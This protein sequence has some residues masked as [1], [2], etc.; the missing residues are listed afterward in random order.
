MTRTT[1]L[2]LI[3]FFLIISRTFYGTSY[4]TIGNIH[5]IFI[6]INSGYAWITGEELH[7]SFHSPFG[8]FYHFLNYVSL[9]ITIAFPDIFHTFDMMFL[10]SI[11]FSAVLVLMFLVMRISQPKSAQIPFWILLLIIPLTFQTRDVSQVDARYP[12]WYGIYNN[13]LWA[14]IILQISHC[15]SW[16]ECGKNSMKI[17]VFATLQATC[18]L[19]CLLF[20]INFVIS[21]GILCLS[22]LILMNTV[23]KKVYLIS[24]ITVTLFAIFA[25][26]LTGYSYTAYFNDLLVTLDAKK[27]QSGIDIKPV[28][29]MIIFILIIQVVR[30]HKQDLI[31]Y[32]K[33]LFV[34]VRLYL[35]QIINNRLQIHLFVFDILIAFS[36]L[37]GVIGDFHRP[38]IFYVLVLFIFQ[39]WIMLRNG[40]KIKYTP[41]PMILL[42]IVGA[43]FIRNIEST[44]QVA[45][46][47]TKEVPPIEE[48]FTKWAEVV[49]DGSSTSMSFLVK[50]TQTLDMFLKKG[51]FKRANDWDNYILTSS[52]SKKTPDDLLLRGAGYRNAQYVED[53]NNVL[54][55]LKTKDLMN[56]NNVKVNY[57]AFT[58]PFPF[59]L[60]TQL[61]D[62]TPHWLHI[63]TTH[64]KK[65][66]IKYMD[67]LQSSD[68]VIMP[69]SAV[70]KE[71]QLF[72]NCSF[73]L[74]NQQQKQ[75]FFIIGVEGLSIIFASEN[76][77]K[78][79]NYPVTL[80][81]DYDR[82]KQECI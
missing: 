53:I 45:M 64:S 10:S 36:I 47:K 34:R 75:K 63:G 25:V 20:K 41:Y 51:V 19:I 14:L 38:Y 67:N 52:Y 30:Y 69:V 54:R 73:Y 70:I 24:G 62:Q 9:S 40:V 42:A 4:V 59:L 48:N 8:Y 15:F 46:K 78:Q 49:I 39:F 43:F 33:P 56:G 58:N 80:I 81:P 13:Q 79:R 5:D 35:L 28:I 22:P 82:I 55:A 65:S 16:D 50:N 23:E 76:M 12:L 27:S 74:W 18:F 44:T 77:V 26:Y 57:L 71:E 21:S 61:P 7:Q 2:F 17:C 11:I 32:D 68:L 6:P 1:C 29:Y 37:L 72:F 31:E 3:F 60:N 66:I